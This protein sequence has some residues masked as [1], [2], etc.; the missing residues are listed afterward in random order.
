MEQ[1]NLRMTQKTALVIG[2]SGGLGRAIAA[3][4]RRKDMP[5]LSWAGTWRDWR[6]PA[7]NWEPRRPT[8]STFPSCDL[9]DRAQT[10][11]MV[12]QALARMNAIDVLVC[13]AG[14]NVRQRSLRSLDPA[15]WD[16]VIAGNLTTA[17]NAIHFVL[18][19]M[20]T[21]GSGLILRNV[22][23]GRI[24]GQYHHRSCV[25]R[26]EICA[27]SIGDQHRPRG[28]R[29]G[30]PFHRDL[31]RRSQYAATGGARRACGRTVKRAAASRFFR[32]R[33]LPMWCA[34]W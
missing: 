4:L 20:R 13:A 2:A 32:L 15:D 29:E 22:L 8:L 5:W 19:S 34:C 25:F 11:A 6:P 31:L 1:E 7:A 10:Q 3:M 16:R 18:P 26:G 27:G 24:A 21:R 30:N 14:L 12:E 9:T 33:I 28:A 17:F 23:P